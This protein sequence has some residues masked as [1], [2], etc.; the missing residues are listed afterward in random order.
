M[1][2]TKEAVAKKVNIKAL[3]SFLVLGTTASALPFFIHIQSITGPIINAILILVLFLAGIRL[4]VIVALV[5]SIAAL[6]G[7]L[8]P[9]PLAPMIPFIMLS[10]VIFI[11]TVDYFYNL[12]KDNLNGYFVGI[13][14]GSLAK[15]FFLFVNTILIIKLIAKQ[16]LA[17]KIAQLM[18]WPQFFTA[19]VG[20]M[21]AFLVLKWLKRI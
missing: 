16:E 19:M 8:L 14:V 10:N 2:Y 7:G 21:I 13:F 6:V 4:A 12:F 11:F 1:N 18:S 17:V 3:S 5:P 20:G 15:F 9:L